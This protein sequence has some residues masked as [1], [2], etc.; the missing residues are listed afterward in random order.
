MREEVNK[1][2]EDVSTNELNISWSK[3]KICL[4]DRQPP[5]SL[6]HTIEVYENQ[7][8]VVKDLIFFGS[9]LS[10]GRSVIIR[11]RKTQQNLAEH[12]CQSP[13]K[14]IDIFNLSVD[15]VRLCSTYF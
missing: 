3:T 5:Q 4:F 8:A 10:I 2:D 12:I 13:Q 14:D 1:V 6:S 7:L 11:P 9:V 15:Q